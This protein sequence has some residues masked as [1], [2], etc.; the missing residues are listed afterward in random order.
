MLSKIRFSDSIYQIDIL[1]AKNENGQFYDMLMAEE[2]DSKVIDTG[3]IDGQM[4]L[5]EDDFFS[6]IRAEDPASHGEVH[7]TA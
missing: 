2:L 4:S 6:E 1:P 7:A 3:G 5:M